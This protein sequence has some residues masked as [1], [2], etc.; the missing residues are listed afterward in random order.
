MGHGHQDDLSIAPSSSTGITQGQVDDIPKESLHPQVEPPAD[1]SHSAPSACINTVSQDILSASHSG[2]RIFLDLCS[3]ASRPLSQAILATGHDVLSLDLLLQP[4]FDILSDSHYE[5]VLRLAASG[6]VGYAGAS[7]PCRHYSRL[8]LQNDDGPPALRTPGH[9]SGVPGLSSTQLEQVQESFLILFRCVQI[10]LLVFDSGGR[11]HL[12]QPTNAMSWLEQF[13]QSFLKHISACCV[14]IAACSYNVDFYKSWMFASSFSGLSMLGSTCQHGPHAHRR[15]Q[16]TKMRDGSYASKVTACYP[17]QLATSFADCIQSTLSSHSFD[18]TL[19]EAL[20][21]IPVKGLRDGPTAWEDG[22]GL[23]SSPDWSQSDRKLKDCFKELRQSWIQRILHQKWDQRIITYFQS[24]HTLP[25]F[26][27]AELAPFCKDLDFFLRSQGHD[28]DWSIRDEQP[29]RLC[30]VNAL[31]KIM[32]DPDSSLFDCLLTG[33]PTGFSNNIPASGF[34]P[35]RA[36]QDPPFTPLSV[37]W[38][39]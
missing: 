37:R 6:Q 15:I 8:K 2:S 30:L 35:L 17:S 39:N 19:Q 33:V 10:L 16:G 24:D 13:V 22:A 36:P 7:P 18:L 11:C 23:T 38:Q 31:R 26:T 4:A 20:A 32:Q 3:G 5:S 25:P 12:E 21:L 1:L 29:M 9:M 14:S 28:N 27:E 34:F